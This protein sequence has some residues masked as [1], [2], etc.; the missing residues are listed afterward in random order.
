MMEVIKSLKDNIKATFDMMLAMIMQLKGLALAKIAEAAMLVPMLKA[1]ATAQINFAKAMLANTK[2]IMK[3]VKLQIKLQ[4]Q[5][6]LNMLKAQ[7]SMLKLQLQK[8]K[9][10]WP[11]LSLAAG[12]AVAA[13]ALGSALAQNT[14]AI[15]N[16]T[17]EAANGLKCFSQSPI[18]PNNDNT[19]K[20]IEKQRQQDCDAL[21]N[22]TSAKQNAENAANNLK[23][24]QKIAASSQ[25]AKNECNSSINYLQNAIESIETKIANAPSLQSNLTDTAL[26]M[27]NVSIDQ[28]RIDAGLYV[29]GNKSVLLNPTIRQLSITNSDSTPGHWDTNFTVFEA[30]PNTIQQLSSDDIGYKDVSDH[31][32][33]KIM[34]SFDVARTPHLPFYESFRKSIFNHNSGNY[35]STF[36]PS[37][38]LGFFVRCPTA[39]TGSSQPSVPSDITTRKTKSTVTNEEDIYPFINTKTLREENDAVSIYCGKAKYGNVLN[40]KSV[41][42]IHPLPHSVK[43]DPRLSQNTSILNSGFNNTEFV[44]HLANLESDQIFQTYHN[45]WQ[46]RV[47][48]CANAVTRVKKGVSR[49]EIKMRLLNQLD[50]RKSL[51]SSSQFKPIDY[52]LSIWGYLSNRTNCG[53]IDKSWLTTS[54]DHHQTDWTHVADVSGV[55]TNLSD[56][57]YLHFDLNKIVRRKQQLKTFNFPNTSQQWWTH[58]VIGTAA[59]NGVEKGIENSLVIDTINF[60]TQTLIK[61]VSGV[62]YVDLNA[63]D[64]QLQLGGADTNQRVYDS[65]SRIELK[66]RKAFASALIPPAQRTSHGAKSQM[67]RLSSTYDSLDAQSKSMASPQLHTSRG[68]SA[69]KNNSSPESSSID[70][71]DTNQKDPAHRWLNESH[72][73]LKSMSGLGNLLLDDENLDA[74]IDLD[75]LLQDPDD[76][77]VSSLGIDGSLKNNFG[78]SASTISFFQLHAGTSSTATSESSTED[79]NFNEALTHGNNAGMITDRMQTHAGV[80]LSDTGWAPGSIVVPQSVES[81]IAQWSTSAASPMMPFPQATL[82]KIATGKMS[83]EKFREDQLQMAQSTSDIKTVAVN[84]GLAKALIE[85]LIEGLT[86][87]LTVKVSDM[88]TI[89]L[90]PRITETVTVAIEDHISAEVADMLL[91]SLPETLSRALSISIPAVLAMWLPSSLRQNLVRSLAGVLGRGLTHS[92][93]PTI[94]LSIKAGDKSSIVY[95]RLSERFHHVNDDLGISKPFYLKPDEIRSAM[96]YMDIYASY[97]S[98]YYSDMFMGPTKDFLAQKLSAVQEALIKY[99]TDRKAGTQA[100]SASFKEVRGNII[101]RPDNIFDTE[102]GQNN[103]SVP[104][105]QGIRF[106]ELASD[107]INTTS[108]SGQTN[109][110]SF[111]N[112]TYYRSVDNLLQTVLSDTQKQKV[113]STGILKNLNENVHNSGILP[114]ELAERAKGLLKSPSGADTDK[115][116]DIAQHNRMKKV[117]TNNKDNRPVAIDTVNVLHLS[118]HELWSSEQPSS[119]DTFNK[120]RQKIEAVGWK[121]HMPSDSQAH[122]SL[123]NRN[124]TANAKASRDSNSN[125]NEINSNKQLVENYEVAFAKS[126]EKAIRH[127]LKQVQ[128]NI[129]K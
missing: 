82:K 28:A 9:F 37:Q 50:L 113:K 100:Q 30:N 67:D 19:S 18:A 4:I 11:H 111:P 17:A 34:S 69:I 107:H 70:G 3:H 94:F 44:K 80:T 84:G 64:A 33:R 85:E 58:F 117:S 57:N 112:S 83:I 2:S 128:S 127:G 108:I 14:S 129:T 31:R 51:T 71:I 62:G 88:M 91:M 96:Y 115:S 87:K 23:S 109:S 126:L 39:S 16:S 41:L 104:G 74:S 92:L 68:S 93:A 1:L 59:I 118:E 66:D 110:S 120:P 105:S 7:L 48:K 15:A 26:A 72:S 98:D 10:A 8:F 102:S 103:N 42:A 35:E 114:D 6:M 116:K 12:A 86:T 65:H 22:A 24:L 95:P 77:V 122:S 46:A 90:T 45:S 32:T 20:Q 121:W 123:L 76:F 5:M 43:V 124:A 52:R 54:F 119:D 73:L 97:Y 27:L 21:K 61:N 89:A 75:E 125:A 38:L 56:S 99:N 25:D 81:A 40:S 36:L 106:E 78:L 60:W 63:S 49:L 55:L 29:F 53:S 79:L 47:V 101:Q 13:V